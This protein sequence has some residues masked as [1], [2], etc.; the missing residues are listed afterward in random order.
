MDRLT[1]YFVFRTGE[2]SDDSGRE[3]VFPEVLTDRDRVIYEAVDAFM[4]ADLPLT[5]RERRQLLETG[6]CYNLALSDERKNLLK[7]TVDGSAG[8]VLELDKVAARCKLTGERAVRSASV[9]QGKTKVVEFRALGTD[10]ATSNETCRK[11][12]RV[13][14]QDGK[15]KSTSATA[16]GAS[17]TTGS[18]A[19]ERCLVQAVGSESG[20]ADQDDAVV[21][22]GEQQSGSFAGSGSLGLRRRGIGAS[23]AVVR[24]S[25]APPTT[26]SY[27]YKF[28]KHLTRV[29]GKSHFLCIVSTVL[30]KRVRIDNL[31]PA[32]A[33]AAG[34]MYVESYPQSHPLKRIG[35]RVK[36]EAPVP[37][38]NH[39]REASS[40]DASNGS[41]DEDKVDDFFSSTSDGSSGDEAGGE[42]TG[43]QAAG[44]EEG[45]DLEKKIKQAAARESAAQ[46]VKA[47]AALVGSVIKH[48][49]FFAFDPPEDEGGES[50]LTNLHVSIVCDTQELAGVCHFLAWLRS[51]AEGLRVTGYNKLKV[52]V[53]VT[54][55]AEHGQA[56]AYEEAVK[57]V[58]DC[59]PCTYT[60]GES[61]ERRLRIYSA[62]MKSRL[63]FEFIY[64]AP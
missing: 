52:L 31:C 44:V 26:S 5:L 25:S 12:S 15:S 50:N 19:E 33:D 38:T 37:R 32:N 40:D 35:A 42:K 22:H 60:S 39:G 7:T 10:Y 47:G 9:E 64:F 23:G 8:L 28:R 30:K 41:G 24:G 59:L 17:T 49:M 6:V 16:F 2:A 18:G 53:S 63:Y 46:A 55:C 48:I 27:R 61:F 58:V 43:K 56:T 51:F 34:E 36:T 21:S 11:R 57:H 4:R 54:P 45:Q 14:T 13:E 1:T 20:P 3:S 62:A 29:D